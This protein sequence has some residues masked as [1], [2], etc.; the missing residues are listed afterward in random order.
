MA[1][2]KIHV[3]LFLCKKKK[4]SVIKFILLSAI[5]QHWRH[6]VPYTDTILYPQGQA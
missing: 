5:M 2:L 1:M 6:G 4:E 3:D